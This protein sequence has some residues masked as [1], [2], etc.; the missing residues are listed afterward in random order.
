MRY[1][2]GSSVRIAIALLA[3]A[4][5]LV[6]C[7]VP[8][9]ELST[10]TAEEPVPPTSTS[11][12]N[13]P[14]PDYFAD[15]PAE[16]R[17]SDGGGGPRSPAYWA[18]WNSC[19]PDNRAEEA[20]ANG[21]RTAGW[22][23]VDDVLADPGLQLGGH[24]LTSCEEGVALLQGRTAAGD[25]TS[26]PAYALAAQLL[27]AELNLNVGAETCPI[28]EEAV[29][30][31]HIVLSTTNFDG[32]STTPLDTEAGGALPRLVDLLAAYNVGSLCV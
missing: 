13:V 6:S 32:V 19:A 4:V 9:N 8:E 5:G 3:V 12:P 11:T 2:T 18:V 24:L 16:A 14:E 20:A 28:A 26:D 30:G 27:A 25:D 17:A 21:G 29:L 22:I 1:M 31:A 10:N 7:S 23:L 15:L